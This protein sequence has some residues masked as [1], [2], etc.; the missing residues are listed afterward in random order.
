MNHITIKAKG[1]SAN[2]SDQWAILFQ[3]F[4]LLVRGLAIIAIVSGVY[5]RNPFWKE[6]VIPATIPRCQVQQR[7]WPVSKPEPGSSTFA[8][9]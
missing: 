2:Q 7:A 1:A 5:I 8:V 4:M 9:Q 6:K 3:K